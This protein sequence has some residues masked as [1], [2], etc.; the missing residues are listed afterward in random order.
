MSGLQQVRKPGSAVE[1][2]LPSPLASRSAMSM[3]PVQARFGHS[4]EQLLPGN[5]GRTT[6]QR[7][8]L[9]DED[10]LQL[11]ADPTLQREALP[12][13]DEL[14][15]KAD[16]TLQRDALPDE[17][18]LQL[19][20]TVLREASG[21]PAY[22]DPPVATGGGASLPG[23]VQTKME[24]SFGTSF[25][26]VRVHQ[27][28][29]AASIGAVAYTRGSDIHF[30]PGAYDPGSQS[31]QQLLGHELTHVV[32]QRAGRVSTPQ[33]MGAPINADHGLE[34]EADAMGARAAAGLPAPVPGAD[35]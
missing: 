19:K 20:A 6:V 4:L 24:G 15:L 30:Q 1:Q 21:I 35:R 8:G 27:G 10:E 3:A 17:D 12:E 34:A 14:Q 11:K 26:D 16:A 28:P 5:P 23:E 33:A 18:E 2:E 31:G 22:P 7:E 29:E 9:A 13:E 25:S 32:Q